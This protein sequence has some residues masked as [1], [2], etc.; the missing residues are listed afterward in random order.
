[1]VLRMQLYSQLL[2]FFPA[3]TWEILRGKKNLVAVDFTWNL[4][5]SPS[6]LLKPFGI[7][8]L[9]PLPPHSSLHPTPISKQLL[10]YHCVLKK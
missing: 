9:L 7:L 6:K 2:N 10:A 5:S 1:M 8:L 4:S 3:V